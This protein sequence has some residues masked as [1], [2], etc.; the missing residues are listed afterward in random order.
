M[1]ISF[2]NREIAFKTFRGFRAKTFS[3]ST[4]CLLWRETFLINLSCAE[5]RGYHI[6]APTYYFLKAISL[7]LAT[8]VQ[9]RAN[10]MISDYF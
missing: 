8:P 4:A 6:A 2:G 1:L 5:A 7:C 10:N 3:I 9:E